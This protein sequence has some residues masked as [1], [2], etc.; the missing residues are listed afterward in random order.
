ME[1]A[2]KPINRDAACWYA[3]N[4]ARRAEE[5]VKVQLEQAGYECY[6]PLQSLIRRWGSQ[7]IKI[8]VP[9]VPGFIFVC[10][11]SAEVLDAASSKVL[12]FVMKPEGGYLVLTSEEVEQISMEKLE[13]IWFQK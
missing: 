4:T 6:L 5:K 2:I 7:K 13:A 8:S 3:V 9:L 1:K 12:S 10:L 11:S